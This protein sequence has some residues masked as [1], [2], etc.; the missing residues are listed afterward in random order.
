MIELKVGKKEVELPEK[1]TIRQYQKI[2]EIDASNDPVGFVRA[3]SGLEEDEIK[4]A[5]KKDMDF[6][7]HFL[8][9]NYLGNGG[10]KKLQ[11]TI[12]H[13][14][15][16]YGLM[17]Q[18]HTLNF[19]GWVDLEFLTT[20]GVE[21]NM[22]KI[23]ALMY[24]PITDYKKNGEYIIE[25][26][27]HDSMIERAELFMDLPIDYFWGVS[28]FFFNLVKAYTEGMKA[29]LEYQRTKEKAL[30]RLRMINPLNHL[31]KLYHAF[32]GL[33]FWRYVRRTLQ[34]LK[35]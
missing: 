14:G 16:T 34:R 23:M 21:K 10:D 20:E 3:V 26:Y 4:Y 27:D 22:E 7:F 32:I 8:V 19:G 11:T 17:S 24:R 6:V 29:S 5:N 28:S 12:E 13:E 30:T 31:S 2:R 33:A 15:I 18:I 1:L 9:E 35:K 25:D